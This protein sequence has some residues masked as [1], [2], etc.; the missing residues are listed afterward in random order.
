MSTKAQLEQKVDRLTQLVEQLI[1]KSETKTLTQSLEEN[2]P[3]RQN[4]INPNIISLK[5]N[6][7]QDQ[8]VRRGSKGKQCR[9]EPISIVEDRPNLFLEDNVQN[10]FKQDIKIDKKLT[11]KNKPVPR[12]SPVKMYEVSCEICGQ[13]DIV[14]ANTLMLDPDTKDVRYICNNCIRK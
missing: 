14:N 4:K 6:N 10:S 8:S 11:G 7:V 3:K 1:A 5:K 12:R 13:V 2:Q 9:T